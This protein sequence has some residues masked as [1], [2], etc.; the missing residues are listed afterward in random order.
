[1]T[2]KLYTPDMCGSGQVGECAHCGMQPDDNGHDG[3]L[4]DLG[5]DVMNACCGHGDMDLM[6]I[7]LG[8]DAYNE[9]PNKLRYS[10]Q[11]ALKEINKRRK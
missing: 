6:Y 2:D 8:H 3:C 7:Q 4:G 5:V 10:G 1:M 9:N 11:R